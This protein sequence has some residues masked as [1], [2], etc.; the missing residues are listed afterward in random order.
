MFVPFKIKKTTINAMCSGYEYDTEVITRKLKSNINLE[1]IKQ[2]FING[3]Q[4]QEGM[5]S[6]T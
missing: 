2:H 5:T 6:M 1:T 4:L 3:T